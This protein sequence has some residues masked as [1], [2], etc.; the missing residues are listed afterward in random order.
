[1]I[2]VRF[3]C[4]EPIAY[5]PMN[6]HPK[7]LAMGCFF[8]QLFRERYWASPWLFLPGLFLRCAMQMAISPVKYGIS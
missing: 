7:A 2:L 3:C 4:S 5:A 6:K 1:V 8:A